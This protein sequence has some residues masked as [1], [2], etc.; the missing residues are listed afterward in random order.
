V[1]MFFAGVPPSLPHINSGRL[2]ALAVT[3]DKRSA[4]MPNVPTV[5]ELGYPGFS[6]ENWQAILVPA[7]TPQPIIEQLARDIATVAADKGFSDQVT[8]QGAVPAILGPTE[9]AAFLRTESAKYQKLVKESGA[10]AD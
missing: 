10:K 4:L 6:I 2:R 8:A 1:E 9:F 7:G 3:T 5:A